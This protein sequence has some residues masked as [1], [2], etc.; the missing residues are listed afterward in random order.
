MI[1]LLVQMN[2]DHEIRLLSVQKHRIQYRYMGE[3]QES[4]TLPQY[5]VSLFC[6]RGFLLYIYE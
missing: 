3:D 2:P 5:D 6:R 1:V 4:R